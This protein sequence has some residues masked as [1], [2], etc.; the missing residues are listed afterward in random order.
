[1]TCKVCH[2]MMICPQMIK[3]LKIPLQRTQLLIVLIGK[4]YITICMY[5]FSRHTKD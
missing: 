2:A 3:P 5:I 4:A 1:M